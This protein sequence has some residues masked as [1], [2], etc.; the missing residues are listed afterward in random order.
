ML[1]SHDHEINY[2]KTCLKQELKNRQNKDLNGK[3]QL[4]EGGKYCRMLPF[5]NTFDLHLSDNWS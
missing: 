2:S 3:W 1:N 4:N 5:C